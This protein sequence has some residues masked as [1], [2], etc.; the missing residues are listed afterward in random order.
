MEVWVAAPLQRGTERLFIPDLVTIEYT[1]T[2]PNEH[3]D[4]SVSLYPLEFKDA[5]ARLAQTKRKGSQP[6]E[7]GNTKAA[8]PRIWP[9]KAANR[10]ASAIFRELN[11]KSRSLR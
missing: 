7:S 1:V 6:A 5:I 8:G 4:T 9:I 10:S 11:T 2:K 3:Q